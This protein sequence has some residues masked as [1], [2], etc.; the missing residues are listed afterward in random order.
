M[1]KGDLVELVEPDTVWKKTDLATTPGVVIKGPYGTV[2]KIKSRWDGRAMITRECRVVDVLVG[3][4]I[5]SQIPVENLAV[6]K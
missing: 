3:T 1:I 6:V 2:K 5:F 4:K